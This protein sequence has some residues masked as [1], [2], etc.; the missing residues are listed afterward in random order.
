MPVADKPKMKPGDK[1][2]NPKKVATKMDISVRAVYDL[3]SE[4]YFRCYYPNGP[5]R[6]PVRIWESSVDAHIEAFSV[7]SGAIIEK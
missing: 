1:L 4:G 7:D 6:R 2:L 3:I 5:G